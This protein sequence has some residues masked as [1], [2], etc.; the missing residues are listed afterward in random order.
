MAYVGF[1]AVFLSWLYVIYSVMKINED[2]DEMRHTMLDVLAKEEQE[3]GRCLQGWKNTIE[4]FDGS[5]KATN[6]ILGALKQKPEWIPCSEKLPKPYEYCL[7]TTTDGRVIY[8][9][10]DGL[11]SNY[12]AWMPLPEPYKK[13]EQE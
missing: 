13:G 5:V 11:F 12:T 4:K 9:H 7:W 1:I 2:I 6:K 8:H 10:C 3:I